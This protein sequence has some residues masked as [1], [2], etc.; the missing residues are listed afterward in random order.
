MNFNMKIPLSRH[1]TKCCQGTPILI[2]LTLHLEE[3]RQIGQKCTVLMNSTTFFNVIMNV[4][5]GPSLSTFVNL[6]TLAPNE[7]CCTKKF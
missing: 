2:F 1:L 4:K 7:C 6:L 3:A 5:K